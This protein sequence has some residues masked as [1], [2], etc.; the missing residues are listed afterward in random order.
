MN[1]N[2]LLGKMLACS[3]KVYCYLAALFQESNRLHTCFI[4]I[5]KEI[6]LITCEVLIFDD[7]MTL[8][9]IVIVTYTCR[10]FLTVIFDTS[11]TSVKC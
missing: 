2:T 6:S 3:L 5:K 11:F 4:S 1:I 9:I 10:T 7:E 8:D